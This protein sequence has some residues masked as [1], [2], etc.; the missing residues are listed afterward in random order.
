MS[1]HAPSEASH[2]IESHNIPYSINE[3]LLDLGAGTGGTEDVVGRDRSQEQ[4]LSEEQVLELAKIG[5]LLE[6]EYASPRDSEWAFHQVSSRIAIMTR[7]KLSETRSNEPYR[8]SQGKIFM[9]QARPVTSVDNIDSE[10]EAFHEGDSGLVGEFDSI[11]KAN[12][13]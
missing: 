3:S 11:T 9:L 8:Q 5:V 10:F 6:R 2:V 7:N 1:E 13:G 4:T 12:V